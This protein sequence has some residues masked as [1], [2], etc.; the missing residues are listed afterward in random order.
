[1]FQHGGSTT[2][3]EIWKMHFEDSGGTKINQLL[4]EMLVMFG[5][6]GF[7]KVGDTTFQTW[8]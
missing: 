6:I 3:R 1:M 4:N 2:Q 7:A 5:Q 8:Y